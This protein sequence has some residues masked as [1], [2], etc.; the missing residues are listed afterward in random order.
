MTDQEPMSKANINEAVAR[1]LGYTEIL[2]EPPDY[3]RSIEAAW[4]VLEA[5]NKKGYVTVERG[6]LEPEW[7][8]S[9]NWAEGE[10]TDFLIIELA[11][12]A[13]L[14]ICKAFLKLP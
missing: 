1:K 9:I 10:Q 12:T 2:K 3:C 7:Q 4:E 6:I 11:D 13:P 14:A 5:M 8:C